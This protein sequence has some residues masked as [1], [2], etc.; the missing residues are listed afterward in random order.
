MRIVLPFLVERPIRFSPVI[1]EHNAHKPYVERKR[2]LT[3][4][5][6]IHGINILGETPEVVFQQNQL[7]HGFGFVVVQL[8]QKQGVSIT[9]RVVARE[10]KHGTSSIS[11][12][13]PKR[14]CVSSSIAATCLEIKRVFLSR[15]FG[16]LSRKVL[17]SFPFRP[18]PGNKKVTKKR[19]I[20]NGIVQ[21]STKAEIYKT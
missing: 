16:K 4:E 8:S 11:S 3:H 9:H 17:L 10:E 2:R 19:Q 15:K 21:R 14:G 6:R 20:A 18:E 13:L 7:R 5:D 1:I 12:S